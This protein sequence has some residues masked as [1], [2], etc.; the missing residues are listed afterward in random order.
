MSNGEPDVSAAHHPS[1]RYEPKGAEPVPIATTVSEDW[2]RRIWAAQRDT[3]RTVDGAIYRRIPYGREGRGWFSD[4]PTCGD[5]AASRG[6]L[7]VPGCDLERCP[8]CRGQML[9][10]GCFEAPPDDDQEPG[11]V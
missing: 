1:R 6:Q 8:A 4:A 10:C 9:S 2:S 5:C 7:H 3:T 11:Y